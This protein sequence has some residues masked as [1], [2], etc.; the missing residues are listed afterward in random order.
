MNNNK[1]IKI[2]VISFILLISIGVGYALLTQELKIIG[3]GS[4]EGNTWSVY[5]DNV[6]V[7]EKSVELSQNDIEPTIDDS[8]RTS[9][10]FAV[11]LNKPGDFYEFNV[12]VVNDGTIDAMVDKAILKLNDTIVGSNNPLPNYLEYR[13]RYDDGAPIEKKLLLAAGQRE[14]YKVRLAYKRDISEEDLA[15][16]NENTHYSFEFDVL[17]V[18]AE[19]NAI[20]RSPYYECNYEGELLPGAEYINGQYIYHYKQQLSSSGWSSIT[21]D[22]WGVTL[23]DPNS[24]SPI[25]TKL[26]SAINDKPIVSMSYMFYN[27]KASV[28]NTDSFNTSKVTNMNGMFYGAVNVAQLDLSVFDTSKVTDMSNM[29]YGNSNLKRID[30]STFDTS[31]V[32]YM[33]NMFYDA[34]SLTTLDLSTFNTSKVYSISNMLYGTSSLKSVNLDNWD[35]RYLSTLRYGGGGF[36]SGSSVKKVSCRNWKLPSTSEDWL[37]RAWAASSVESIDVTGWDLQKTTSLSGLFADSVYLKTII[38]LDTWENMDNVTNMFQMFKRAS[39]LTTLDLSNFNTS[40]VTN[41]ESMFDGASGLTTLDLSSFNTS[42]VTDMDSMFNG[43]SSLTTLDLS[44]FDTSNVTSLSSMLYGTSSLE[45]ANLDNWDLRSLSSLGTSGGGFFFGS[46]VKNVSCKKWKLPTN[47]AD[48]LGR[49]WA[50][51]SIETLDVTDWDLKKT[52][53]LSGIFAGDANLKTIIGLNTLKNMGGVTNL[54]YMFHGA[55]GLTTLDLSNFDTSNVTDM[56]SMF[57]GA[58]GLTTLDL[59]N[60]DTSKVTSLSA[61]LYGTSSLE[62]VNLDNWDLTGLSSFS[63][64]GGGFFSASSVKNVS[65]K[66]WK[67]P[68]DISSWIGSSWV[69]SNVETVDVT[70]W[71]LTR[72][73]SLA[74]VFSG[75]SKLKAITGLNTWNTSN[76]VSMYAMFKDASSLTSLNLSNFDTSALSSIDYM[77]NGASSLEELDFSSA[78][79]D[80][81]TNSTS[82]LSDVSN[83]IKVYVKDE[84]AR[85]W[86]I[87]NGDNAILTTSN[88]LI[89]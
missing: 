7:N 28:I 76:I 12:D 20:A 60:F 27:S 58:S 3:F 19:K 70:G 87:A 63:S 18:Q 36:F 21:A 57:N 52:T 43:A 11:T 30:L 81:V 78:T 45:S 40:K 8:N 49:N 26:C 72:T 5:F 88:V 41:M 61:M 59:S 83:T 38:G 37:G 69:G 50:A 24:T 85:D 86:I 64:G 54:S 67:V 33:T 14:T 53:N 66:N 29:F 9:V 65:C 4:V 55:S 89:K 82:M 46:S 35:L 51:S 10:S 79:F 13:V 77:F 32:S 74:L 80:T 23:V 48:W 15:V 47:S 17:F 62:S 6:V 25:T 71:N 31:K 68:N 84:A 22:G 44:N 1:K 56:S 75:A 2:F 42:K 39:S 73:R 34:S 16:A